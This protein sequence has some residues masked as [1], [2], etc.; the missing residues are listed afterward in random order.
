VKGGGEVCS[1]V[2]D[3]VEDDIDVGVRMMS[4]LEVVL[5]LEFGL[6]GICVGDRVCVV[7]AVFKLGLQVGVVSVGWTIWGAQVWVCRASVVNFLF[8]IL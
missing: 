5:V 8:S 6:F 3:G 7:W 4:G 2:G 1:A